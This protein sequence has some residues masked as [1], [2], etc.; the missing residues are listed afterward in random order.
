MKIQNH[1]YYKLKYETLVEN[2]LNHIIIFL[3]LSLNTNPINSDVFENTIIL[4]LGQPSGEEKTIGIPISKIDKVVHLEVKKK[5]HSLSIEWWRSI[6]L[7]EV[8]EYP[9]TT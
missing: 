9:L 6:Y 5:T 8:G 1:F 2:V 7:D 4:L 3:W